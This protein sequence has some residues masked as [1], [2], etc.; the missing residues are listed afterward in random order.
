[1]SIATGVISFVVFVFCFSASNDDAFQDIGTF[2]FLI[3]VLSIFSGVLLW[4]KRL[5]SNLYRKTIPANKNINQEQQKTTQ[6]LSVNV[7][8]ESEPIT[9]NS[10][11]LEAKTEQKTEVN[12]WFK[13]FNSLK[14]DKKP[15]LSNYEI[16]QRV[17]IGL[18]FIGIACL[19]IAYFADKTSLYFWG[20]GLIFVIFCS[21]FDENV[22]PG[23]FLLVGIACLIFAYSE[24]AIFYYFFAAG[25][26][27]LAA[28]ISSLQS[29]DCVSSDNT[30][31][32][33]L[34]DISFN[35]SAEDEDYDDDNY[36]DY[37]PKRKA[38]SKTYKQQSTSVEVWNGNK[39][40]NFEYCDAEG[41]FTE[42]KIR[43]YSIKQRDYD[44]LLIGYCYL[45]KSK[46]D[47]ISDRIIGFI[48]YK[49][50]LHQI[51]DILPHLKEGNSCCIL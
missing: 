19:A 31:N 13:K 50:E 22:I 10:I 35:T 29:E 28:Y 33:S 23:C 25:L 18:F 47:F 16:Y 39:T 32:N 44:Y 4:L 38:K 49:K 46:R 2:F 27:I 8:A 24:N 15:K 40:I 41:N 17:L 37:K 42:R 9:E 20:G 34:F 36:S 21:S 51:V 45:R 5:A 43:L 6:E 11:V 48:E 14:A 30:N 7:L 3:S 12:W 1:M 26:I